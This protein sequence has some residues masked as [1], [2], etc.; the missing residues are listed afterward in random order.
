MTEPSIF[1][2]IMSIT[3]WP[4]QFTCKL[5]VYSAWAAGQRNVLLVL[6]TGSGKTVIFSEIVRENNGPALVCAH[7]HEL[8]SQASLAL[9]RNGLRHRVIGSRETIH[10]CTQT[11]LLELGRNFVDPNNPRV[12]ASVDTLIRCKPERWMNE[13][14][15]FVQDEAHHM[16]RANKWGRVT[17]LFKNPHL[18]ILGVTAETLRGDGKGLG[19]H[20]D[21]FMRHLTEGP[22]SYELI[23]AGRLSPYRVFAPPS[24]LDLTGVPLSAGGDYSPI[25]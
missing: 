21:G 24:D 5:D 19:A 22:S 4:F 2:L 9:A 23:Q 7:R 6:P 8:V 18:R 11:H 1:I 25:P 16:L 10:A 13:I 15:L 20:A 17:E 14:T 3:L 12:V